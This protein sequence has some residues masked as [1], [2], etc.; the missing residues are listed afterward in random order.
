MVQDATHASNAVVGWVVGAMGAASG[1]GMIVAGVSSDRRQERFLHAAS[2]ALLTGIGFFGAALLSAPWGPVLGLTVVLIGVRV[3][4]PGFWCIP[5]L[6]LRGTAASF[7]IGLVTGIGNIGGFVG[8]YA[9]GLLKDA[10]GSTRGVFLGMGVLGLCAAMLLLLI[11]R[12]Q[13]LAG[14]Q[15]PA[16]ARS[17]AGGATV[18]VRLE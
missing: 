6:M 2:G 13:G 16:V 8:P 4:H 12:R 3:F 18:V 7:G 9:V 14:R 1:V 5:S 15:H 11:R 17:T 10:S